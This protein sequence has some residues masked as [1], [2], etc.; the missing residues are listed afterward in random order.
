MKISNFIR[1]VTIIII[2]ITAGFL[3]YKKFKSTQNKTEIIL[4]NSLKVKALLLKYKKPQ[5][6]EVINYIKNVNSKFAKDILEIK[7][8]K[9]PL[10]TSANFYIELQLFSDE[11]DPTAPLIAQLRFLQTESKNLIKEESINLD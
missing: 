11:L 4:T 6:V 8:L 9:I 5:K 1:Q 3:M 7:Q 2:G 10:D